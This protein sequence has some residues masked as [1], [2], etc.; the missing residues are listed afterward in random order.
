M[1]TVARLTAIRQDLAAQGVRI[2]QDEIKAMRDEG[3]R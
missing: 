3:R 1:A 2:T